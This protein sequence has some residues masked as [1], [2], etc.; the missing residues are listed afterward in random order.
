MADR[1]ELRLPALE[2]LQGTR[3]IYLFGVD[4]KNLHNFTTVSRIRRDTE[5]ILQGYQRPE[6]QSHIRAIRRYLES[7]SAMLPNALVLAFDGRVKFH[8][9]GK[10]SPGN[11]RPGELII[12]I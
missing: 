11:S 8:A 6:V 5:E 12:P 9:R 2:I 10:A 1:Y 7:D 3:R 4:G